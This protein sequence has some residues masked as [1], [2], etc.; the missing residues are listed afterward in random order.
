VGAALRAG[1][2]HIDTVAAYDKERETGRAVA[3]SGVLRDEL[4]LVTEL[5]NAHQGYDSTLKG[6]RRQRRPAR[7]RLSRPVP[8]SLADA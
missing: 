1:Y 6:V 7:C 8:D 5:W 4:Y 2:R 3:D